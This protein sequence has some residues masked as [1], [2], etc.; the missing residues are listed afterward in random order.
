MCPICGTRQ[1]P[2]LP[3]PECRVS[4][5]VCGTRQKLY[6]VHIGL[7]RVHWAHGKVTGSRSEGL[8]IG[9]TGDAVGTT[10]GDGHDKRCPQ[11]RIQMKIEVR[12]SKRT[13][14]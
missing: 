8:G 11:D 3:T 2:P 7:C 9:V 10:I 12:S 5:A 14:L 1:K 6:R 13:Q 4:F